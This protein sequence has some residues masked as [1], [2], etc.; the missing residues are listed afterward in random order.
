MMEKTEYKF[1]LIVQEI[2]YKHH[3][4]TFQVILCDKFM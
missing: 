4:N 1:Y 3:I 2:A